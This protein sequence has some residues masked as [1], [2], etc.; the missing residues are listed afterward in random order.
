MTSTDNATHAGP[1]KGKLAQLVRRMVSAGSSPVS[2]ASLAAFRIAFGTL[3]LVATIRFV[4]MGWVSELYIEPAHHFSYY[5]FGWIQPWPGWGMYLHFALMSLASLG[6][7]V[8]YRYRLSIITF[9]LLFTYVEL[10]DRTTY[11]NHYYF[12]SLIYQPYQ[13]SDDLSPPQSNCV[14]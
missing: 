6:V 1:G 9:F 10:I 4:A 7:A 14:P 13:L 2:P 12:I 8:G 11:L 3:C 5:G